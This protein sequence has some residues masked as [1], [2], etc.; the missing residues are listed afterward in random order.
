MAAASSKGSVLPAIM[1]TDNGDYANSLCGRYP[2]SQHAPL[3]QAAF[4]NLAYAGGDVLGAEGAFALV[5]S[6]DGFSRISN[7]ERF[8]V[9]AVQSQA[10]AEN[11]RDPTAA[12]S[13]LRKKWRR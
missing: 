6:A 2:F 9:V 3:R 7:R 4:N 8:G 10:G 5:F 13:A 1:S 12:R 11:A